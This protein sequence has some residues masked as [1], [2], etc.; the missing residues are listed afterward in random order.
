MSVRV[1]Q[2][3]FDEL[4]R[5]LQRRY[6]VVDGARSTAL[7]LGS[8]LDELIR[9]ADEERV[10][11]HRLITLL[12]AAKLKDPE[13]TPL[14]TR[15]STPPL[16]TRSKNSRPPPRLPPPLPPRKRK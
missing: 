8:M 6:D 13:H 9:V 10:D 15:A 16:A 7:L 11:M 14:P 5:L 2:R 12:K 1:E 4:L 3:D